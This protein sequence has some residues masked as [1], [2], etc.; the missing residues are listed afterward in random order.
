MVLHSTLFIPL[1][2]PSL[3]LILIACNLIWLLFFMQKDHRRQLFLLIIIKVFNHDCFFKFLG[4]INEKIGLIK[5]VFCGYPSNKKYLAGYV[6]DESIIQLY[7]W[8][9]CFTGFFCHN[10]S[11]GLKFFVSATEAD[12]KSEHGLETLYQN[13]SKIQALIC[14]D[15]MSFSGILPGLMFRKGLHKEGQERQKTVRAVLKGI[16][17]LCEEENLPK[18]C[19]VVILGCKGYIGREVICQLGSKICHGVDLNPETNLPEGWP[20]HLQGKDAILVNISR[21]HTL[22]YY[23]KLA[24]KKLVLLNEVYPEPST[25]EVHSWRA[26]GGNMYHLVG[27]KGWSLPP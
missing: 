11:V 10:G 15:E 22:E 19:P 14:A 13:T 5:V 6:R 16:K 1:N 9:P 8:K 23:S 26:N 7:R 12:F 4:L 3:A 18:D 20:E 17:N 24:W 21:A 25:A 2:M 27:T